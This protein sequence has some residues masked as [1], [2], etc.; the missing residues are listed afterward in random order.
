MKKILLASLMALPSSAFA[1]FIGIH[2]QLGGWNAD[3]SGTVAST[4]AKD[5]REKL[6]QIIPSF[7][8][9]GFD[10]DNHLTGWIALEHPIPFL[11]N[12]RLGYTNIET[13]YLSA[14]DISIDKV[15]GGPYNNI[16]G[17]I[18]Y[19][20][21]QPIFTEL[22]LDVIDGSIYWELLDNW[23]SLDLGLTV[24][25]L[26]GEFVETIDETPLPIQAFGGSDGCGPFEPARVE[27]VNVGIVVDGCIRPSSSTTTPIDLTLPMLYGKVRFDIPM[28]GFYAAGTF[29][30]VSFDG[31]SMTDF[32]V[33]AGYMFDFT[34]IELG[35]SIGYRRSSLKSNDLDGLYA[36]S[37]LTGSYAS[38]NIHF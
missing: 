6:G 11:P 37:D 33:Q 15:T 25:N 8:E 12:V 17:G 28:S 4:L 13:G 26:N 3:F 30:G 34:V 5:S 2:G 21:G 38:L 16:P 10:K 36:D 24:R 31:N 35:A 29:Q 7:E 18:N 9:R 27:L 32:D 1:D 19:D 20:S 22:N 23:V 14:I